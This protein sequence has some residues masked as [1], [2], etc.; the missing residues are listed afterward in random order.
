MDKGIYTGRISAMI[1]Q[2]IIGV[3]LIAICVFGYLYFQD[4]TSEKLGALYGSLMTGLILVL[5]Q[6]F[7]AREQHILIEKIRKLG[8]INIRS[9]RDDREFYKSL[10]SNAK[11]QIDILGVTSSRFLSHFADLDSGR[12]ESKVLIQAL[13]RKVNVRILI[14]KPEYLGEKEKN[15][16]LNAKTTLDKLKTTHNCHFSFHYFD[17]LPVH[18]IFRVDDECLVGPVFPK[19]SSKDSPCVHL[20]VKSDY[21]RKYL[22]YFDA[23]WDKAAKNEDIST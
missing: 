10:I 19:V 1:Y 4:G 21:A 3:L 11:S 22:D 2:V 18:S 6:F 14:P 7:F 16:S 9:D 23:E 12:E 17:H 5:V 13:E 20:T 8:I 15:D